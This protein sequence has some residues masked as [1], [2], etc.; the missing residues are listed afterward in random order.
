MTT[1]SRE[2]LFGTTVRVLAERA[3]DARKDAD[4]LACQA[5]NVRMLS[6]RGDTR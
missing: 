6:F 2:Y 5:W 4:I 1:K 3:R